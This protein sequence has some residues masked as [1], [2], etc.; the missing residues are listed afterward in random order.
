MIDGLA[1]F[2]VYWLVTDRK[3]DSGSV[4]TFMLDSLTLERRMS[5]PGHTNLVTSIEVLTVDLSDG[6]P[7]LNGNVW[8]IWP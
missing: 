5:F 3:V 8:P 2:A 6:N 7:D 1:A 4:R